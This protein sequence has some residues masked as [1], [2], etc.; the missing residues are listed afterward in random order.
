MHS[1]V[2]HGH[3]Q[4]AHQLT[5]PYNFQLMSQRENFTQE[6]LNANEKEIGDDLEVTL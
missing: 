4:H 5:M 1:N 3:A 6:S 2:N